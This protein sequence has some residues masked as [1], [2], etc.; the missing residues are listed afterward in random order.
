MEG[1][2]DEEEFSCQDVLDSQA[3]TKPDPPKRQE[4]RNARDE[5]F[6][7]SFDRYLDLTYF[8]FTYKTLFSYITFGFFFYFFFVCVCDILSKV[9]KFHSKAGPKLKITLN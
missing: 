9:Q 7:D 1:L 4:Q 8:P 2:E 6:D 5:T 3:F